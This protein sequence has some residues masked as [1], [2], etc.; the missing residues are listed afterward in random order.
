MKKIIYILIILIS[1]HLY[2]QETG[3]IEMYQLYIN[4]ALDAK[5][6]ENYES[7]LSWY[8]KSLDYAISHWG[9]NDAL[10]VSS[11]SNIG[12]I[13]IHL[14]KIEE[15]ICNL[16][17]C[18]R[19]SR[20]PQ[21]NKPSIIVSSLSTLANGY[22]ICNQY[23]A[24]LKTNKVVLKE[25]DKWEKDLASD[26][27]S[28]TD[29]GFYR[30]ST[31]NDIAKV[32]NLMRQY[33]D[34]IN[35]Y[36]KSIDIAQELLPE[37]LSDLA[38]RRML[39]RQ[40]KLVEQSNDMDQI[41]IQY[42]LSVMSLFNSH[43]E[44]C[45]QYHNNKDYKKAIFHY[46]N[47]IEIA[48]RNK[49][50]L[51][52]TIDSS[53]IA[54][55]FKHIERSLI[56]QYISSYS[57]YKKELG[58]V[59]AKY[60][61]KELPELCLNISLGYW[62]IA[63]EIC[64]ELGE[65]ELG[66]SYVYKSI[67]SYKENDICNLEYANR[68]LSCADWMQEVVGDR[69]EAL[70]WH[71]ASI[72]IIG[73]L[74]SKEDDLFKTAISEM[75]SCYGAYSSTLYVNE[76]NKG[77]NV[78]DY[79]ELI[80]IMD[81]WTDILKSLY[82]DYGQDYIDEI[83]INESTIDSYWYSNTY[84]ATIAE[85][86]RVLLR[87]GQKDLAMQLSAKL[88]NDITDQKLWVQTYIELT[89]TLRLS[90]EYID[91]KDGYLWIIN[92]L[93]SDY[94][95]YKKYKSEVEYCNSQ[96]ANLLAVRLGDTGTA[97]YILTSNK[98][99]AS[100]YGSYFKDSYENVENYIFDQ[101]TW[102]EIYEQ[103]GKY[104]ES[105]SHILEAYDTYDKNRENINDIGIQESFLMSNIGDKYRALDDYEK[106]EEYLLKALK[107]YNT[108]MEDL[109][110]YYS[111]I[112]WPRHIYA[113]LANLYFD[114][115]K[116]EKAEDIFLQVYNYDRLY[117]PE[118]IPS[119]ASY[120]SY[121]YCERGDYRLYEKYINIGWNASLQNISR[122]FIT[123]TSQERINYWDRA[124]IN[125]IE[126]LADLALRFAP[127]Y[128]IPLY[129][130]ILLNK[131]LLLNIEKNISQVVLQ[132][133]NEELITAYNLAFN[134]IASK[135]TNMGAYE[136]EFMHLY[137]NVIN[138]PILKT[139]DWTDVKTN[140]NRKSIGI[141]FIES[142]D[143]SGGQYAALLL[144]KGWTKPKLVE[145]CSQEDIMHYHSLGADT[146]TKNNSYKLYNLIWSKLEPYIN[147]GDNVYFS[148]MGLL[149]QMNIEVFQDANGKRANEKWNLHR[150]SS[151][152]ELCTEK[153]EI[154]M[155]SAVL[156]GNLLYD[157]DSTTM[158]AESRTY[159]QE[160]N[161]VASRGFV[162]D[163]T[164]RDG[165]NRLVATNTEIN[166]IAM[167]MQA[168][169]IEPTIYK[170]ET[171]NEE[172]FKALSGK[173]T[174]IIHLATHGF[175]YKDEEAKTKTFFET[176]DMNKNNYALDNSLKRSGLILAGAQKAWLGE[177]IPDNVEDGVL[178]AEEIATM[179]LTGTDLVVLSA[180]ETGLG[181]ITSEWV[182]GL[183]RAFKKAGV[184]TLIMSL[185]KVDDNATSLFM[186]TFYK[187][188][189]GGKSKHAA[190]LDAQAAVR[191]C[192][193]SDYS[194]PYYWASF[195]MLD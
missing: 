120:L 5:K 127:H 145:L 15:G 25:I 67:N 144:R 123:M 44:L 76:N 11:L 126:I 17:E 159:R 166:S 32:H 165:W 55:L 180:C 133:G 89:D 23:D 147:E 128:N 49:Y 41:Y 40:N 27:G 109:G 142:I 81:Y 20:L 122:S 116:W 53:L 99:V 107:S 57:E 8:Q 94:D 181:E 64:K 105:L 74:V 45:K 130:N 101:M 158:V 1:Q 6:Y 95:T 167:T 31:L 137:K 194:N 161:Y 39:S 82:K 103:A 62:S 71:K 160:D 124:E 13:K 73:K 174:P 26:I 183:Q 111:D 75:A 59:V 141:E 85:K 192:K 61:N 132:S 9:K 35:C 3:S 72:D 185:W 108:K 29:I 38:E 177:P 65:I 112:N 162:Q 106:A 175:F 190:F 169:G 48:R 121:I 18:V 24:A 79:T 163:S 164:M 154:D 10:V 173:E 136:K 182:F 30:I 171:G 69:K 150:V 84:V 51:F 19:I 28:L 93:S 37:D 56:P 155:T 87:M 47:A 90:N 42:E 110:E 156:Y 83:L 193:E 80:S 2:A 22:V 33:G 54:S 139:Y 119:A 168:C 7:A 97:M 21:N 153:P 157:V 115:G 138:E 50:T 118:S 170:L 63:Y 14:G 34:A 179:D 188:W 78:A 86:F 4:L 60:D 140:I 178:L 191:E 92:Q 134:S 113:E 36:Q 131:G 12:S 68:L 143:Y 152:R 135:D 88:L 98:Y 104:Q 149:H 96:V 117:Y 148:P 129:N 100:I 91:A 186:R 114:Q 43:I 66:T 146:Y 70:K 184:Q 46:D 52:N 125:K 151:T 102:A 189:L 195:I 77:R 187:Q 172:S 176:L 58:K 16:E